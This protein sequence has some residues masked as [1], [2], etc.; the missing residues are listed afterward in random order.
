MAEMNVDA[1]QNEIYNPARTYLWE[2]VIPSPLEGNT[3]SLLI[4]AQ[5]TSMPERSFGGILV[6]FKQTGGVKF[7]GKIAYPHSWDVTFLEGED[8]AMLLTF[9]DWMNDIIHDRYFVGTADY[10]IDIY[11]HLL[12]MDET[13]AERIRLIGCYPERMSDVNLAQESEDA[14]MVTVTFSYDRWEVV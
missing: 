8:R 10:K 12:N 1:L 13:V 3:R 4:R 6:P 2:I 14:I 7:V 11:L 9:Y 5:S